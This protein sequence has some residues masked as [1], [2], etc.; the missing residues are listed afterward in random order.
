MPSDYELVST[1]LHYYTRSG[2]EVR[3]P[4]ARWYEERVAGSPLACRDWEA[5]RDPRET[6]YA[7]YT[8]LQKQREEF[9]DGV[10]RSI[11]E[12]GYDARLDP[13]WREALERVLAPARYPFHGLQM[14]A[15]YVGQMAPAGRVT[16]ACA[17]QAADE[18]RR[19]QR[20]AY[21]MAQLGQ[22]Y[23]G[24]GEGGR[25][26]WQSEPAWQP[27]REAIERLL[28]AYDWGEAL[29]A[30]TLILK[31]AVD[32]FFTAGLAAEA[33]RAGDP[34]F[35]EVLF[36]LEEDCRWHRAWSLSLLRHAAA[37]RPENRAAMQA[38]VD[39][40]HPL[41]R[42]AIGA[43]APLLPGGAALAGAADP[44]AEGVAALGLRLPGGGGP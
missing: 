43:L 19:V 1:G 23:P 8:R 4:L 3:V 15:A 39:Q 32:G 13:A 38:F 29:V 31:P 12:R 14:A 35:A 25:R 27:L 30:L 37:E 20:F 41:A 40:W 9:V 2:F 26:A 11:D 22:T 42:R 24:F 21:R 34:L 36:S 33:G 6:T 5:F 10:L 17:F 44:C 16:I 18:M 7:T 28:V